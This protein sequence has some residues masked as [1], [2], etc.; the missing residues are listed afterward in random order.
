MKGILTFV[1]AFCGIKR[2]GGPQLSMSRQRKGLS[3]DI[4]RW[5]LTN[6]AGW[7]LPPTALFAEAGSG[8]D[9]GEK[10]P[11]GQHDPSL[12]YELMSPIDSAK[13]DQMS[14]SALAYLGDV[15]FELFVRSRYVWPARRMSDLQNKVVGIVRGEYHKRDR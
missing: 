6:I 5:E 9:S 1:P 10:L 11:D 2:H 8:S 15:V 7:H 3:E 4:C 12:F 13:P 14:A